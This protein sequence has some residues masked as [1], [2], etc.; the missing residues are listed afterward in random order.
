MKKAMPAL[1]LLS[2]ALVLSACGGSNDA[3]PQSPSQ[4]ASSPSSSPAASAPSATTAAGSE[5]AAA[6]Q[7]GMEVDK[8]LF[9]TE[10]TLPASFFG[11]QTREEVEAGAKERGVAK[12]TANEDGSYTYKMSNKVYKEM[13]ADTKEGMLEYVDE[14]KKGESFTS[15]KDVK[16]NDALDEFTLIVDKEAF[17]NSFDSMATLGLSIT[18][19]MYQTLSGAKPD[20][21]KVTVHFQDE[22]TGE[23]FN[24][25]VFPE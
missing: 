22:T 17:E 8:G 14:L 15:I 25:T 19:M 18:G 7:Q 11:G 13:L 6:S 10:V 4:A 1:V 23:T 24:T 2:L 16:H 3:A 9:E 20:K 12:V 21:L 5:T